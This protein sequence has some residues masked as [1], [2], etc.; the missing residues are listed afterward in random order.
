M[1]NRMVGV[2]LV[3]PDNVVLCSVSRRTGGFSTMS[4]QVATEVGSEVSERPVG[5]MFLRILGHTGG[6]ETGRAVVAQP[7]RP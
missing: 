3:R 7:I 6:T 4:T 5:G 2:G 1:G